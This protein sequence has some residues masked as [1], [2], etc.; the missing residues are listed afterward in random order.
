MLIINY[1]NVAG[2]N[3]TNEFT[4]EPKKIGGFSS[5][6]F[7]T[8]YNQKQVNQIVTN[9]TAKTIIISYPKALYQLAQKIRINIQQQS[10]V[11]IELKQF[12]LKDTATTKYR[13]DAVI[14]VLYF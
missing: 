7:F 1:V 11:T 2:S 9:K 3:T 10:S 6:I 5:P 8:S 14:V 13:H 12:D 4:T